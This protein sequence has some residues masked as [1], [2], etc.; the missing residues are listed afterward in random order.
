MI[1][2]NAKFWAESNTQVAIVRFLRSALPPSYRVISVPNGRF[3]ADPMTIARLK[4][5]G[6]TPGVFDL[7]ILRN[8][9]WFCSLEVKAT[10]GKLSEEQR[11][12]SDWLSAGGASQAVVR[13][14]AEAVEVLREFGVTL[15]G[16]VA[17]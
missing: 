15:K 2:D 5:E 3:K 6:L 11:E 14:L 4:R 7:L 12:W 8:D 1:R 17:A 9:G 10:D 13:S 16:R